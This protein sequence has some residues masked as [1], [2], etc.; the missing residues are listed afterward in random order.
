MV[1]KKSPVIRL[2]ALTLILLCERV[3]SRS[4]RFT[5]ASINRR[6]REL[7]VLLSGSLE[8]SQH[9]QKGDCADRCDD[10]AADQA[11]CRCNLENA[12]QPGTDECTDNADDDVAEEAESASEQLSGDPARRRANENEP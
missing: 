10:Q 3:I 12:E 6:D 4:S 9:G 11:A 7:E 5:S 2:E 8:K 1:M